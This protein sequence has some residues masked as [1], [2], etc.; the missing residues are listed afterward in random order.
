[1]RIAQLIAGVVETAAD[2]VSPS[3]WHRPE[4]ATVS[5]DMQ[6]PSS[7]SRILI[8]GEPIPKL[9]GFVIY[10]DG[11]DVGPHCIVEVLT[12]PPRLDADA[13][14]ADTS[15][16]KLPAQQIERIEGV[17]LTGAQA[18]KFHEWRKE[19]QKAERSQLGGKIAQARADGRAV[20]P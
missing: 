19:Q 13:D 7:E 10:D 4:S 16:I 15:L 11:T 1:M 14:G 20:E 2:Q 9:V 5:I 17:I 8:D 3:S 18:V 12:T 6:C